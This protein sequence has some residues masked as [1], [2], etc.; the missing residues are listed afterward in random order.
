MALQAMSD[1]ELRERY[2]LL[3][4]T[5]NHKNDLIQELLHRLVRVGSEYQQIVLDHQ[6]EIQFNRDVQLRERDLRE[7]LRRL[8]VSIVRTLL[9]NIRLLCDP[10]SQSIESRA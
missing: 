7:K 6:R 1:Q 10:N 3:Q 2:E 5:D 8:E 9:K 4:K